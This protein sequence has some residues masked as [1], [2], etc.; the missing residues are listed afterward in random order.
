[1]VVEVL[2]MTLLVILLLMGPFA[3][4]FTVGTLIGYFFN[5]LKPLKAYCVDIGGAIVG[6]IIFALLSFLSFSPNMESCHR[7]S[8]DGHT[9]VCCIT[10]VTAQTGCAWSDYS[11]C[12]F[13]DI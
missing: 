1:M 9:F 5:R 13:A 11:D 4:M 3:V 2:K 7:R 10:L 6:S 8:D 12:S